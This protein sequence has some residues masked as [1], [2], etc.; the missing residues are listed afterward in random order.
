MVI[1]LG[2]SYW[3]IC[4]TRTVHYR[5]SCRSFRCADQQFGIN[6]HRI[7][8]STDA[9]KQFKLRLRGWLFESAY[10]TGGVSGRRCLKQRRINGLTYLLLLTYSYKALSVA[11]NT[12]LT[13]VMVRTVLSLF[14]TLVLL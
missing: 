3:P 6:F 14:I 1:L 7:C 12:N 10:T 8:K 4:R 13:D 5:F 9:R 11:K 2:L